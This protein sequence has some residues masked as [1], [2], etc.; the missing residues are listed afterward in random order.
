MDYDGEPEALAISTAAAAKAGELYNPQD[1][2]LSSFEGFSYY[3][4]LDANPDTILRIVIVQ[5]DA[6]HVVLCT[7]TTSAKMDVDRAWDTENILRTM[8]F[9]RP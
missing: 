8:R 7:M 1:V 4:R 5:L 3:S 9:A 6:F 2:T